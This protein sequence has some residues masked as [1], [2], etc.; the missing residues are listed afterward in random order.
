MSCHGTGAH[1]LRV[2]DTTSNPV[3]M[4]R[5]LAPVDRRWLPKPKGGLVVDVHAIGDVGQRHH[6]DI[7][8]WVGGPW[9]HRWGL[10]ETVEALAIAID[11]RIDPVAHGDVGASVGVASINRRPGLDGCAERDQ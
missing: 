5:V 2:R 3:Q 8:P 11:R 7:V 9:P 10:D 1:Y 6:V 4:A